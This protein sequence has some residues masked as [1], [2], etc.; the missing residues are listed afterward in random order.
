MKKLL[1]RLFQP[2]SFR[3]YFVFVL[4][5]P[6][7][8][9]CQVCVMPYV[10]PFGVTPNLL[11]VHIAIITVAYGRLQAFW[12]GLVYGFLMEIRLPSVPF[13]Q[14]AIYPLSS[15][16][17]SF[18]FAD[19]SLR[20]LQMVRALKRRS[21]EMPPLLR[22]VLCAMVNVLVY[23]II[24]VVYIYLGGTSLSPQHFIRALLDV[25]E[26]GAL[27][28]FVALVLRPVILGRQ[29]PEPVLKNQPIVFGKK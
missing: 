14:L 23:E 29:K 20:R 18:A 22:T 3:K 1:R 19:K 4:M 28:F 11:Y 13:V 6:L 5:L 8:F 26:T 21:R 12:A 2:G 16:F 17:V 27:A 7:G 24:N 25:I 9:L 10:R 15:L